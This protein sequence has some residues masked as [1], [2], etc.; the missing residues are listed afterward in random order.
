MAEKAFDST[1]LLWIFGGDETRGPSGR[2]HP[3][4]PTDSMNIILRAMR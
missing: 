1:E 2:L 4:R 3:S